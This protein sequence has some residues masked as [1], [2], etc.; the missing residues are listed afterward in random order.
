M[1]VAIA[2]DNL[3]FISGLQD[4]MIARLQDYERVL[5]SSA[6]KKPVAGGYF[7]RYESGLG[8]LKQRRAAL[9][10][11]IRS[12]EHYLQSWSKLGP[13]GAAN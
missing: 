5:V 11:A 9:D 6:A 13:P 2:I 1:N 10:A 8:Y 12:V 7:N 3:M 4:D